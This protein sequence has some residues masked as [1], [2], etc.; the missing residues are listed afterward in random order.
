[1]A[2]VC[3]FRIVTC[4]VL[5]L[6]CVHTRTELIAPLDAPALAVADSAK[7]A[8]TEPAASRRDAEG[9]S[10]LQMRNVDFHV[11]SHVV[12]HIGKLRGEAIATQAG[13]PVTFD[14]RR[15]FRIDIAG[16]DVGMTLV[17]LSN[18][19][20]EYVFAYPGAPLFDLRA[21]SDGERLRLTGKL[22]KGGDVPF[23]ILASLSTTASGE[24]R[25]HPTSIR[26]ARVPAGGLLKLVGLRLDKLLN[27]SGSR[28][29]RVTGNDILLDIQRMIPPPEIRGHLAS[30][31]LAGDQMRLTFA[32]ATLAL[33]VA[34]PVPPEPATNY[35]YFRGGTIRIG[36]LFMVHSD[37]EIIDTAPADPLD[38][39]IDQYARQ[40]DAGFVKTTPAHGLIVHMPD[41]H[42]LTDLGAARP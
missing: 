3:S 14:D 23:E 39:D 10:D 37:L 21:S 1:M 36:K 42:T 26:I 31:H 8:V 5:A 9:P 7:S 40:L 29:A 2:V 28:G 35:L 6:G 34:E 30:V 24:I 33:S 41:L 16:A 12:I 25:L 15:S 19:L 32:S 38:F 17:D 4:A 20:N 22:H 11:S 18:L 27:L 13:Q